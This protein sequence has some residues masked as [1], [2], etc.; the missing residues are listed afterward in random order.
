[1]ADLFPIMLCLQGKRCLLVGGGEVASRKVDDLL[2]CGAQV[3]VVSPMISAA[4]EHYAAAGQIECHR[5]RFEDSD[6]Q[7]MNM[8]ISA[9]DNEIV[10]QRVMSVCR[11]M[12]ILV[13]VVDDPPK[14]D[15]FVPA[16][17]RRGSLAISVSTEGKSPL[18][19]RQI[20]GQLQEEFGEEYGYLVEIL[21]EARQIIKESIPDIEKRRKMFAD[22]VEGSLLEV[23]REK[24]PEQAREWMLK[25]ISL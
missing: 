22:L 24:G 9:T 6:V 12:G 18:L 20:K 17:V 16:V 25:C 11:D 13:N 5:R 8:V 15:F 7:G 14:C 10:N 2:V 1:M 23:I 3:Q 21:G 19:A 4:I